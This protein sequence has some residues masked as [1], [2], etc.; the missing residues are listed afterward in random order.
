[1]TWLQYLHSQTCYF[2]IP[3]LETQN[4]LFKRNYSPAASVVENVP[5]CPDADTDMDDI[6]DDDDGCDLKGTVGL[7]DVER[8][9]AKRRLHDSQDSC[10][11]K[12]RRVLG[13]FIEHF[14]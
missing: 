2:E 8:F 4:A 1:M 14:S 12:K 10:K 11:A 6:D 9:D 7:N 5:T 13:T 3:S